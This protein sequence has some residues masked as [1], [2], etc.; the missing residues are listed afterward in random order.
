MNIEE[1]AKQ[2]YP[3]YDKY[4][5]A[6]DLKAFIAFYETPAGQKMAKTLPQMMQ[7]M[8]TTRSQWGATVGKEVAE[9][10]GK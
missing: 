9:E 2:I 4:F 7:E 3:I 8:T 10:L 5:T 6:E 1:L